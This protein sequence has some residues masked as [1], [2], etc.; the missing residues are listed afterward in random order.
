MTVLRKQVWPLWI[1]LLLGV[2]VIFDLF[3]KLALP[4]TSND[5]W[6]HMVLGHQVLMTGSLITDHSIFTWTPATPYHAYN[7]WLSDIILYL[8]HEAAGIRGLLLLRYGVFFS[9]LLI[10]IYFVIKRGLFNHPLSWAIILIGFTLC[11]PAYLI[12]PELFS[13]GLM[14]LVVW[15]FYH[16]RSVGDIGWRLV[17]LFPVILIVWVNIHGAFFLSALF[18]MS[19][20]IGELLNFTFNP[21]QA[22]S[23]RLRKHFF[24]AMLL[25]APAILVNPYGIELPLSIIQSMVT[26]STQDYN[27]IGAYQP[28]FIFN[29]AP[30][31]MLDYLVLAMFVFVVLLWQK[32]KLRQTDWV[33]VLSFVIFSALFIQMIRTTYFLAPVF[34]FSSLDLLSAKTNSK[35][36]PKKMLAKNA[37][38]VLSVIIISIISWRVISFGE[39]AVTHSADWF[40]RLQ[41]VGYR[42]PKAEA[43]YIIS[44]QNGNKVGNLYGDGGYLIYRLWP[45]KKIMIDPRYFPFKEWIDDHLNLFEEGRDVSGYVESMTADFWLINYNNTALFEW[46]TH[47]DQWSLAYFGPVGAVFVPSDDFIGKTRYSWQVKGLSSVTEIAKVLGAASIMENMPLAKELRE[48]AIKNIGSD[49]SYKN[50]FIKEIDY[51]LLGIEALNNQNL[52]HAADLFAKGFFITPSLSLSAKIYRY[53]AS[54]AWEDKD[55]IRARQLSVAAHDVDSNKTFADIY[56]LALTDWHVRHGAHANEKISDDE[57]LWIEK[58]DFIIDNKDLIAE[59]Q[60]FIVDTAIAMKNGYY[61]GKADLF[62]Q[63]VFK[64]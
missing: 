61:D 52:N 3:V 64:E 50:L 48:I 21:D 32:M 42:F 60:Q 26:D 2:L 9:M 63:K 19:A 44:S 30:H 43:D 1:A 54:V 41:F 51:L 45:E 16:I 56:N 8:V 22:M 57:V 12:K 5:L 15:L 58:V 37:I 18:F 14:T 20:I 7:S 10:A 46:F 47:S 24:V 39:V 34:V 55:Y 28:T 6:W 35:L 23:R 49:V 33:V 31:F 38:V 13:L 29:K 25:C 27:N 17:Y 11:W 36:W 59:D 4:V 40:K 53:L 62:Q